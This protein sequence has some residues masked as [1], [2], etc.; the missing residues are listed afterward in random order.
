M[1]VP[2]VHPEVK[3][4]ERLNLY[5]AYE[6]AQR[7]SAGTEDIPVVFHRRSRKPWLV[8]MDIDDW[9]K[10]YKKYIDQEN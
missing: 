9:A 5:T 4:C 2:G 10:I 3:R 8:V 6:Q 1:G 7:D